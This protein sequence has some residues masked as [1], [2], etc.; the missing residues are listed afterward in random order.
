MCVPLRATGLSKAAAE[1]SSEIDPAR[2]PYLARSLW[3]NDKQASAYI[4]PRLGE[5]EKQAPL[6]GRVCVWP[7]AAIV[8]QRELWRSVMPAAPV[9]VVRSTPPLY[10]TTQAHTP[11][12]Y[13]TCMAT[14]ELARKR[15]KKNGYEKLFTQTV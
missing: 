11:S 9:D 15:P 4:Q 10:V 2:R 8:R 5:E 12:I 13:Y 1:Q 6:C 3:Q 7:G 14:P